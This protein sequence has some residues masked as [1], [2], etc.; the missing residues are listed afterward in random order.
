MRGGR[1]SAGS[2]LRRRLE[3]L[4]A[5][6]R[7]ACRAA[8]PE[9]PDRVTHS[10]GKLL[11]SGRRPLPLTS[12][13]WCFEPRGTKYHVGDERDDLPEGDPAVD[14]GRENVENI[15]AEGLERGRFPRSCEL[16]GRSLTN[17]NP[18]ETAAGTASALLA[19]APL[20]RLRPSAVPSTR[21]PL[22]GWRTATRPP[23]RDVEEL[24]VLA[25]AAGALGG[26][27]GHL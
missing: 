4:P 12:P 24:A 16:R 13:A 18:L 10:A 21:G 7:A 17:A 23:A 6:G 15:G 1:A 20:R 26:S 19:M 3:P 5:P 9:R 11:H 25:G 22:D 8:G 27:R 2:Y 14:V